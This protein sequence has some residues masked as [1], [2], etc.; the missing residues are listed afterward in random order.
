MHRQILTKKKV[1]MFTCLPSA[2][3]DNVKK[4]YIRHSQSKIIVTA[5]AN[6]QGHTRAINVA[7]PTSAVSFFSRKCVNTRNRNGLPGGAPSNK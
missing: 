4:H 3:C 2:T 1:A 6:T 7:N 5:S